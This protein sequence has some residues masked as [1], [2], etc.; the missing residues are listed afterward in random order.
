[1]VSVASGPSG[2]PAGFAS[3]PAPRAARPPH[4]DLV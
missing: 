2:D 3:C 4:R 1:M